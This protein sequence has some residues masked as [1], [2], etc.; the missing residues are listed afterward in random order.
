[1]PYSDYQIKRHLKYWNNKK[2]E[3]LESDEEFE[4]VEMFRICD[5]SREADRWNKL[6]EEME[7]DEEA[8][9]QVNQ[10]LADFENDKNYDPDNKATTI[11]VKKREIKSNL[12]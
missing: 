5:S 1:M 7:M 11:K 6:Q 9:S 3:D 2:K 4:P 10:S 12:I 8:E